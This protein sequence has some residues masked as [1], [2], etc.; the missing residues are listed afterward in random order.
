M[1]AMKCAM[2]VA[3]VAVALTLPAMMATPAAAQQPADVC[4]RMAQVPADLHNPQVNIVYVEP[5]NP[6]YRAMAERLKQCRVLEQLRVFL[7]PLKLPRQLT[8]NVEECG[9]PTRAYKAQG[10]VTI[11]YEL[12]EQIEKVAAKA[13]A[14]A[15]GRMLIGAFVQVAFH[16]VAHAVFDMLAVPVWGRAHDAAD[17][18]G[19][20]IMVQFGEDVAFRTVLGTADFFKLSGNTWTG[21]AFADV[22]SP[23]AQRFFNYLCIAYGGAPKSF[24]FLINPK[25]NQEPILPDRRAQRCPGEYEQVRMAFNL[26]I[27]PHVDPDKLV[28]VRAI[29]WLAP[30]ETR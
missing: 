18:L 7:A 20:F 5:R 11:C 29:Q 3:A 17:R 10:P 23:D 14:E 26:R 19:A 25:E 30:G 13:E 21:N 28:R 24:D 15:R 1:M 4:P 6:A 9:A 22:S 27:M 16:E 8:V 12:V 2:R